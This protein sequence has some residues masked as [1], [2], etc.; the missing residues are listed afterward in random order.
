MKEGNAYMDRLLAMS[1]KDLEAYNKAYA[2]KLEAA[3]VA[4]DQIYKKDI[5]QLTKD[6]KNELKKGFEDLPKNL[7]ELGNQAMQGFI[8]GLTESTDYMSDEIKTYI[9]A[10]VD[11]FK[12]EL[13]INSPSKVMMEIGNYTG[14]GLVDGLK[15]T[16]SEVKETATSMAQTM[17]TPL[18]SMKTSFG[19]IKS[20][21]SGPNG[22]GA[23]N[24][25]V[26]NNYNLVQ[27]NNSPKSLSALETYQARRQQV[28]MVK[29]MT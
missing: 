23:V 14:I 21:V 2:E 17:A 6:Y 13:Q 26:V 18:D 29:A 20:V 27:N 15:N 19:D 28:A 11:T 1:A 4:G 5:E 22:S 9:S 16:I 7:E 3:Q 12:K 10:M 25:S 8:N 24:N